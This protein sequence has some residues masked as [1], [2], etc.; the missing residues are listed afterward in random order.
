MG[1][2]FAANLRTAMHFPIVSLRDPTT[3]RRIIRKLE[4]EPKLRREIFREIAQKPKLQKEIL[5]AHTT[6]IKVGS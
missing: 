5:R 4:R 6:Y 2:S 3:I 1:R